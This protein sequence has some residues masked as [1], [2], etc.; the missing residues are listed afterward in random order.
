MSVMQCR[1]KT[2]IVKAKWTSKK[3]L[4]DTSMEECHKLVVENMKS[5]LNVAKTFQM[6][7]TIGF[8]YDFGILEK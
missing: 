6:Q 8:L 5:S 4:T 1:E 2:E 7:T 3:T